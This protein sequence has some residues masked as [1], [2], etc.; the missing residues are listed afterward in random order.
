[1][2]IC[3]HLLDCIFEKCMPSLRWEQC[4]PG[5]VVLWDTKGVLLGDSDKMF[6]IV[7]G[8]FGEAGRDLKLGLTHRVTL[9]PFFQHM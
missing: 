1:M 9:D 6:V 8:N 3:V 2:Q 5:L 4:P 7:I